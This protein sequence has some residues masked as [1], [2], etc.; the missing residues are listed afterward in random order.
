M[1]PSNA[2]E[3]HG[4]DVLP[5]DPGRRDR[6]PAV[7]DDNDDI[8]PVPPAEPVLEGRVIERRPLTASIPVY[9]VTVVRV[10]ARPE[11]RQHVRRHGGYVAAGATVLYRQWRD[12]STTARYAR[13][14]RMAEA[15]GDHEKALEWEERLTRFRRDRHVRRMD[16]LTVPL[17]VAVKLPWIAGGS[18]AVLTVTG[19][20]LAIAEKNVAAVAVPF[21]VTAQIVKTAFFVASVTW[22]PVL[23]AAPWIA[24]AALHQ[25]GRRHA[26]GGPGGWTTAGKADAEDAGLVMT[27]DTIVLALRHLGIRDLNAAFKQGWM[28]TFQ[29]SP[30]RDGR[31]YSAVFSLPL[32]VTA[33]MVADQRKVLARNLHRAEVETWPSDAA[34][35]KDSPYPPGTVALWVADRG[36]LSQATPEYPLMHEG[37]ADVFAGV[38]GGISPRG[39]VM[40]IPI[41]A[42]NF[43]VG[44]HM[45][46][47]KSNA[48][49]VIMLGCAMDP[50][51]ELNVF[52]FANNGDFD[53]YAP[54]LAIYEKGVED[55]TV[56]KAVQRLH[57]LSEEVDRRELK[58]GQLGAKKLTRQI[59]ADHPD[60]RPIV[61]LFSEC[62]E[63]FGHPEYGPVAAELSIK[64]IKRS[65]KTGIVFGYDTQ[66]S[67]KEAIP[68]ALVELLSV[69]C[70]FY[71][72]TWN[73]NDGFLGAGSFKA[74]IRATELRPGR[75]RG[76]SL[77]TGI[78][79]A[80]F[81]LLR[82]YFIEVDDDAGYDAAA[83]VIA[84]A[85]ANLAPG[86]PAHASAN[87]LPPAAPRDLLEDLD[88]VMGDERVKL[89]DLT[90][91][92][93]DHAPAWPPY[94][95][96]KG[97]QLRALLEAQGVRVLTT[98]NILQLDPADLRRALTERE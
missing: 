48:C 94:H 41:F 93:R 2:P 25:A 5:F 42:A 81:E 92:L 79:D 37:T 43:D 54:R 56:I 35:P 40:T 64:T 38:P 67:R 96:M 88:A 32:G 23:L 28:P 31:G 7:A 80:Q 65:R 10:I 22:G 30:V 72:K 29:L 9:A 85:V 86:T 90:A 73:S 53:A 57:E 34:A 26:L 47:G 4:G 21:E 97:T 95:A 58:L 61:V 69:N 12:N 11:T 63:L 50:L 71:V 20:M 6:R 98:A 83:E 1:A 74:G 33:E 84:R 46:Q 49:R 45:G 15:A 8:T 19:I 39:D 24:L 17:K 3:Q 76:T 13:F 51:C 18:V 89:A 55:S 78:S 87:A 68:P 75:D 36:V 44:G 91:L 59:A 70:C 52:V 14:M 62:H 66:S 27:A 60:M 82:W 16:W 77:V